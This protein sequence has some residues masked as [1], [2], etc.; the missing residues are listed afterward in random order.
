LIRTD[1]RAAMSPQLALNT[2]VRARMLKKEYFFFESVTVCN[3]RILEK[4][5][6]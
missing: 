1:S 3:H 2:T 6:A 4:D 5:A